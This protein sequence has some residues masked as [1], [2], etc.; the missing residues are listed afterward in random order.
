MVEHRATEVDRGKPGMPRR[1]ER[2]PRDLVD[3]VAVGE[4]TP[5][6]HGLEARPIFGHEDVA[7][8]QVEVEYVAQVR[9]GAEEI[10]DGVLAGDEQR[11]ELG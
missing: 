10:L 1:P 6:E 4:A 7:V 11:V 3:E 5:I 2:E 8:D 9:A